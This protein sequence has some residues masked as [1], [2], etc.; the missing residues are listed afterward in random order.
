MPIHLVTTENADEFYQGEISRKEKEYILE[1]LSQTDRTLAEGRNRVNK[2]EEDNAKL[3]H[4]LEQNM[5]RINRMSV[6]FDFFVDR[7]WISWFTCLD[8]L[9]KISRG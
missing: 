3:R 1:K 8:S 5:S 6:D 2:L 9:M 7:V 4:A